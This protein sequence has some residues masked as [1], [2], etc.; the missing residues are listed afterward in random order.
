[1]APASAAAE[2]DSNRLRRFGSPVR[3]SWLA[4]KRSASRARFSSVVSTQFQMTPR[5]LRSWRAS[6][7]RTRHQRTSPVA[8]TR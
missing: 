4:A 8:R 6:L 5:T 1:M 3:P 2:K 7:N